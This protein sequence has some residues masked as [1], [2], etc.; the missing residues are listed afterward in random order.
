MNIDNICLLV[1]LAFVAVGALLMDMDANTTAGCVLI[2]SAF[3]VKL[4][5]IELSFKNVGKQG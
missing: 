3:M 2:L 1:L 5:W 4:H